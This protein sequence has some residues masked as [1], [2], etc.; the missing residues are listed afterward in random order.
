MI[1]WPASPLFVRT[2]LRCGVN[3]GVFAL[4]LSLGTALWAQANDS[5][6]ASPKSRMTPELLWKLNR[7][8]EAVLSPDGQWAAYTV[9]RFQLE[10]NSGLSDLS[11]V[12]VQTLEK[13]EIL[14]GWPSIADLQWHGTANDPSLYFSA[15][16]PSDK[17]AGAQVYR[18]SPSSEEP[19]KI[20]KVTGGVTNL[21][22]SP[23]E[24]HI[25]YTASVKLDAT[26]NE[27]YAD[28]PKADA[29]IIDS[30]LYRHWD[31][32]HDFQYD[33]LHVAPLTAESGVGEAKDLMGRLRADCPVPPF[34]GSS[35]FDWSPDGRELAYT[36]KIDAK[37][38]ESTNSD[39]YL[40]D[41]AGSQAPRNISQGQMG[42]DN[43]PKYSPDGKYI[44][45]SSM[46]IRVTRRTETASCCSIDSRKNRSI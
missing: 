9:R 43:D 32:W 7:L 18:W 1:S 35:Q 23:T 39:I 46:K 29:R 4:I 33:H 8:S 37:M 36:T 41:V 38:A 34:G 31:A 27:L 45:Y 3:F 2:T 14:V 5:A 30:L 21:K 19:Q 15:T 17:P 26:V 6:T 11:L 40:V 13:K 22:V 24:E 20:S 42:Y 28:L 10:E 12:H 44:A 16:D 25:A